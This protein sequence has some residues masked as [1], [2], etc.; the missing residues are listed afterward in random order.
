MTIEKAQNKKLFSDVIPGQAF[1]WCDCLYI[2][3][4][5]NAVLLNDIDG[6]PS[7]NAVGLKK[8]IYTKFNDNDEV[9]VH[10]NAKV[11]LI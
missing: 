3:A 7:I 11:V 5:C 10:D 6:M 9:I 4:E 1:E 2:K 8:G